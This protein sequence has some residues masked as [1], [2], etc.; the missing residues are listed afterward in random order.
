MA[1]RKA[2]P[3]LDK[4][5]K[6]PH[7]ATIKRDAPFRRVDNEEVEAVCLRIAAGAGYV[8]YAGSRGDEQGCKVVGFD[9]AEKARAMQDWIDE[10]GI[11]SRPTPDL[12]SGALSWGATKEAG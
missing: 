10:S 1:R 6:L 4:L 9:T 12:G 11:A 7:R 5:R 3:F 8:F 2:N